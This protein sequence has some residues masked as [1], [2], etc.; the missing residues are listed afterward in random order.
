MV[1]TGICE[2][3]WRDPTVNPRTGRKIYISRVWPCG[4]FKS[5]ELLKHAHSV[6]KNC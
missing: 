4:F 1:N 6:P 3:W 5:D 2:E